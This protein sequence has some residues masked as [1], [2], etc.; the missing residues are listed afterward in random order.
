MLMFFWHIANG[1]R[2]SVTSSDPS[3]F[4]QEDAN[5]S[6]SLSLMCLSHPSDPAVEEPV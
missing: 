6:V 1:C 5:I 2:W 3:V 4:K